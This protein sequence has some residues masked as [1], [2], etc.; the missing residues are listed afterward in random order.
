MIQLLLLLLLLL[1]PLLK[2]MSYVSVWVRD[3]KRMCVYLWET[4]RECVSVCVWERERNPNCG[5][6]FFFTFFHL[7]IFVRHLSEIVEHIQFRLLS[8][9]FIQT[10]Q[11]RVQIENC[12]MEPILSQMSTS[13][14][15]TIKSLENKVSL[16]VH[17]FLWVW[18]VYYLFLNVT[19]GFICYDGRC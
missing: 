4:E 9:R 3:I 13:L 10:S 6:T 19:F 1:T 15:I 7:P 5:W 18:G 14:N 11:K 16:K 8:T 2:C 17:L 12:I